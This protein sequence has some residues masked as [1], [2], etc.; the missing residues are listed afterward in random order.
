MP[1]ALRAPLPR[2][3]PKTSTMRSLKPLTTW[4]CCPKSGVAFTI[5]STLTNRSTTDM[6]LTED[7]LA[8]YVKVANICKST[9]KKLKDAEIK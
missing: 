4:G 2:S 9:L 1:T 5:P 7:H 6:P 3:A 8:D